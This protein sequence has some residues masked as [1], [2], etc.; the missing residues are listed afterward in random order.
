MNLDFNNYNILITG[1]NSGIGRQ[2][3]LD[4]AKAG[5]SKIVLVARRQTELDA[6]KTEINHMPDSNSQIHTLSADLTEQSAINKITNYCKD[7][8]EHIDVIIHSAGT[9]TSVESPAENA[10]NWDRTFALN[11]RAPFFLTMSTM[12]L[13]KKSNR[14][15]SVINISSTLAEKPIPNATAYNASKAALNQT[16]RSLA[17]ELAKDKIRVNAIMPAVVDTPMYAGRFP[18]PKEHE[19]ALEQMS[20][21]HPLGRV[22]MPS[23]ISA[24]TLF[25]ASK[26][27]S[28][29]T[30]VILPVDGGMLCT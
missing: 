15:P 10:E 30:G 25:L 14:Y 16:T 4:F 23:D 20:N 6:I 7:H 22:G 19:E 26:Q 1:A 5:A 27:A 17:L 29:I 28:W 12:E 24:A 9:F 3:A 11:T 21:F 18:N 2:V 13:L 8:L